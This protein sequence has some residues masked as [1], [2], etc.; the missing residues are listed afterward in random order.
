MRQGSP[1]AGCCQWCKTVSKDESKTKEKYSLETA[2]T[3]GNTIFCMKLFTFKKASSPFLFSPALLFLNKLGFWFMSHVIFTSS[4][5]KIDMRGKLP[6]RNQSISDLEAAVISNTWAPGMVSGLTR[7]LVRS[8][9]TH[10]PGC[11]PTALPHRM[12]SPGITWEA[13]GPQEPTT[14]GNEDTWLS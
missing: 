6:E 11:S 2:F 8:Q 1:S 12:S 4:L 3:F 7:S 9:W 13:G 10:G 5:R 14:W